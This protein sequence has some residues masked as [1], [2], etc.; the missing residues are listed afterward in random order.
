MT[1]KEFFAKH[2]IV[3]GAVITLDEFTKVIDDAEE[4]FGMG[5]GFVMDCFVPEGEA[6]APGYEDS[7][8]HHRFEPDNWD[9]LNE[10]WQMFLAG[11]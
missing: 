9:T 1:I 7:L 5:G 3:P 2:N 4:T 10:E 6:V 11:H 8:S